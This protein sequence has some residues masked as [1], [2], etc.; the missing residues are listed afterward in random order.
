MNEILNI[1]RMLIPTELVISFYLSWILYLQFGVSGNFE[2]LINSISFNIRRGMDS[3]DGVMNL[4]RYNF[5]FLN[6]KL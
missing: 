2:N 5:F 6:K 1:S 3:L 4:Y